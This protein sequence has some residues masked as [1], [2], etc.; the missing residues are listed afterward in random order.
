MAVTEAHHGCT[1]EEQVRWLMEI[2][3]GVQD[4]RSAGQDIR[5]VTIWSLFGAVDWNSLLTVR[6]G[7]Y[8][9]GAF[10][11]R[12]TEPRRTAIGV[13]AE[14]L[15]RTGT[16]AHPVLDQQGWWRR[17]SRYYHSLA[18]KTSVAAH[19]RRPILIAGATGTLGRAFA[20][21]CEWR[22]LDHVLLTRGAMDITDP[23]SIDAALARHRPWAVINAAGYVRVD[24]AARERDLCFRANARGGEAIAQA[25]AGLGLP[26]VAFSSDR[27]FDGTLGRPYLE[28]DPPCPSCVYGESKAEAERR[29]GSAHPEALVIRTS[30]FFGPWDRANF[31]YNVLNDLEAGRCIQPSDD[32]VSPTYVPDL[33]H[34]ALDL[35]IDGEHGIWH[36]ANQGMISWVELAERI[37]AEVGLPW[38]AGP[39]T[40]A[41]T[42]RLTALSS[43]RGL[44]L[45]SVES[46]V[47]RYVRDCE[48]DWR[49]QAFLEAAE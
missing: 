6:N 23:T 47:L 20:R 41:D 18:R 29:I 36:L 44:I 7:H 12:G 25:C 38:R 32:I 19:A 46:A 1:R 30:A 37:A 3:Q 43:G 42:P 40:L 33:V 9:P 5:A 39:R 11:V 48:V 8:E 17:E 34:A 4:L 2:W 45:P 21:V 31:V 15:S 16:F 49:A 35:L 27:V 14:A 24:D 22:G 10:D 13:A 28:S 26:V